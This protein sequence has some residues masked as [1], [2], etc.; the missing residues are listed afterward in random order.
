MLQP[1]SLKRAFAGPIG[2]TKA[3]RRYGASFCYHT[4]MIYLFTGPDVDKARTKAFQWVQAARAKAPDAAYIRLSPSEVSPESLAEVAGSQGLFFA[5]TLVLLD[6]PFS[7]SEAGELVMKSLEMLKESQNPI[8]ILAPKLLAAKL[9]KIEPKAE[10]VFS[11]A[12]K[13]KAPAR[14]FNV[15][16][17]NALASKNNEALW[18]EVVAALRQGDAPEMIHGLFHWKARDLMSKGGGKWGEEGARALSL[19]LIE[20]LSD[21]RSGDLPLAENLERFALAMK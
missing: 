14:G 5:K 4:Y 3:T 18:K 21:S 8:A 11:F 17:V 2:S 10:K 9:K 13:A 7:E 1:S 12:A 6:D 16:L 20:L 15:G 19:G